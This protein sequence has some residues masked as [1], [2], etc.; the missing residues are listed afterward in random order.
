[1]VRWLLCLSFLFPYPAAYADERFQI[2]KETYDGRVYELRVPKEPLDIAKAFPGELFLGVTNS[3]AYL[4][5]DGVR[6]ERRQARTN[7]AL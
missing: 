3:H 6:V 2:V 7:R 1:M 5:V 4:Y